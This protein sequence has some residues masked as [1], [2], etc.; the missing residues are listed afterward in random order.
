MS[1]TDRISVRLGKELGAALRAKCSVVGMTDSEFVRLSVASF[2]S[3][4]DALDE[5]L[6]AVEKVDSRLAVMQTRQEQFVRAL[7]NAALTGDAEK[8]Q[9]NRQNFAERIAQIV[10]TVN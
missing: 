3:R 4:E 7:G 2:L 6:A 9:G 5:Y 8:T 1:D 10:D